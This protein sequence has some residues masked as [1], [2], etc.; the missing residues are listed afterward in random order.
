MKAR[1][2]AGFCFLSQNFKISDKVFLNIS[3]INNI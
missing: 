2:K 3:R 1:R